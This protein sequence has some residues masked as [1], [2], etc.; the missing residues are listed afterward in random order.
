MLTVSSWLGALVFAGVDAGGVA[1]GGV[2][3][4]AAWGAFAREI[5]IVSVLL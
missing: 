3:D 4:A 5:I 1:R 2:T